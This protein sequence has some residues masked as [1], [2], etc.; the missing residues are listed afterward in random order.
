M[1]PNDIEN[2]METLGIEHLE[3]I[4]EVEEQ[5]SMLNSA[6]NSDS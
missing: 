2:L 5:K 6:H 1:D 4:S 3:H